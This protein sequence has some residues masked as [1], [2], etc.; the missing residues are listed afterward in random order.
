MKKLRINIDG[1]EVT[2]IAGQTIL[3]ACKDHGIDI[4]TLC[5]D[6]RTEIYGS[7]GLC[8]VEVAG[9]PKLVK[10]C[11]TPITEGMEITT[12]SKRIIESRK[13]N[14]EL[15][16]SNHIGD[17]VA[18]CQLACP[19]QTDCQGYVGL[20]ANGEY[21]AAIEL[22][23]KKLPLP[24]SIG[25]VCPHPCEKA[26]RRGLIDEPIS[27]LWLKRFAADLDIDAGMFM[28][29]IAEDSG[30]SVGIIGGGPAGLT[31]AYF[32]RAAGHAVTIYEAM[33]KMGGM[34]RY[35]I[36]EYRLPKAVLDEEVEL[37][38]AMG[39]TF[40]NNVRV[41]K[42]I[43]FD[44]IRNGHDAVFI[45]LGA[46]T[47][48]G[49]RCEGVDSEG[50][51]G[52][53]ELLRRVSNGEAFELGDR[54][55]V[56]G[57]GNTAM[58]ACRTAVRLG[59]KEVYNI[60]RRTVAEMPAEE[61]EIKEA[62][63]EGVI[64]KNLCNPA[65]IIADDQ[66][67]VTQMRLQK[68]ALGEPDA[69]G[70]RR[71]V[72]IEG[73]IEVIDVDTVILAIGQGI[74]PSGLEAVEQTD[75]H[76]I[77]ADEETFATNLDGVFAGGDCINKGASI[78]IK[79]I[80]DAKKAVG[81]IEDYLNG[82]A[83]EYR[84]PYYV[85]RDDIDADDL[86]GRKPYKRPVMAHLAPEAR[87]D[88]FEEIVKGYT[89]EQAREEASRCLE[90]GCHDYFECKL[91]D[92]ANQYDV[93]P[94]RFAGENK[95]LVF[96]DDHPFI[97]RNPNKCIL[98]GR[99]VRACEEVVGINA[100]GLVN[101]GFETVVAPAL[102][103]K[104]ADSGCI[105]CGTCISVCPTGALGER[106]RGFK[107]V[108]TD[109]EKTR[110]TCGYCGAGCQVTVEAMGNTIVKAVPAEDQD[111]TNEGVMCG[112]GRFGAGE[113]QQEGRLTTPM[114][115]N[116]EGI[117][118]PADWYKAFVTIAKKAQTISARYGQD[119]LKVAVSPRMTTEEMA[120]IAKFASGLNAEV[121]SYAN[122]IH[123]EEAVLG[124]QAGIH[125]FNA[126][127]SADVIL[128][129]GCMRTVNPVL[130]YKLTQAS[131][132]GAQIYAVNPKEDGMD[133]F[134]DELIVENEDLE[135]VAEIVKA[136]FEN[137]KAEASGM[138]ILEQSLEEVEVSDEAAVIADALLD[139]KNP[140][141]LMADQ[142]ITKEASGLAADIAVL[143]GKEKGS[144]CGVMRI[145]SE[146]NSKGLDVLG[147]TQTKTAADGAKGLL[148]FGEDPGLDRADYEFIMVQDTH[149]TETAAQADV[150]LPALAYTEVGGTFINTEGRIQKVNAAVEK[151]LPYSNIGMVM[152]MADILSLNIGPACAGKIRKGLKDQVPALKDP[153]VGGFI[154]REV[155]ED[156]ENYLVPYVEGNLFEEKAYTD[157]LMKGIGKAIAAVVKK[158]F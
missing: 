21:E 147:I 20:I 22:I 37:I 138:A 135:F 50:V 157:A 81:F 67:K 91:V 154:N 110:T 79:A 144:R 60:Y 57:G 63:E 16:L 53:I 126:L 15:L 121:F 38:E 104:L 3:E 34:L 97:E 106:P 146:N 54:V 19:G 118:E 26:C 1:R 99:C 140:V 117:L 109:T 125:D 123:G 56:V 105:A 87:K 59:A 149:L 148:I 119:A 39:T 2:G 31:A 112:R 134:A 41:G 66:G 101:R 73:E 153:E 116:A 43:H 68:M 18:P 107:R 45:A 150:V 14:L 58:D 46:W 108:P 98:C 30:K 25:R 139:A 115:R 83:I 145:T 131:R 35:G 86:E 65:E 90:C 84:Q 93:K 29:E 48:S 10:A 47:S 143:L 75:W 7:C 128:S 55:A 8:V 6:E 42:D 76:T 82:K 71:P 113:M 32:L 137:R 36:P 4:P 103:G 95:E 151:P 72:P 5:Y 49:L 133:R 102:G 111:L 51:V 142:F 94:E 120:V 70:R 80:G 132:R 96:E 33:P 74:D 114:I 44:E 11:A 89:P 122:R 62:Q 13:T 23:K 92:Y 17:C 136:V 156:S 69:S 152:A 27:I 100:L 12:R 129:L 141:I 9:N 64:F 24:A 127:L 124:E 158:V 40:V 77:I 78:A 52:G 28:P 155:S 130:R 88:N 85:T 61:D